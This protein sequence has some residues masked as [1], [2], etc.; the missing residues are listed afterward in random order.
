[1]RSSPEPPYSSG[2]PP[3][4]RPSS[5]AFFSSWAISPSLCCSSSGMSG[6]TSLVTNSS[7]AWPISRWS[8]VSSAGVKT[9]SA[10]GDSRRKP[11][12]GARIPGV[13]V[14]AISPPKY[15]RKALENAR[16]AH[17]A[18]DAHG[19]HAITRL[20]ALEFAQNCGGQLR[21]G[22]AER[23]AESNG[24][25][26]RIDAGWVETGE[27]NYGK[28]LRGEGLVQ[29]DDIDLLELQGGQAQRLGNREHRTDS[30]L[31]RRATSRGER[32]KSRERLHSQGAGAVSAHNNRD[33]GAIAP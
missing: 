23:M 18:A 3:P 6:A 31:F 28:R 5:P 8:S 16:G 2:T 21:A 10:R 24:A 17:A 19:N 11:P 14:V 27:A 7:A 32:H 29:L 25:A 4:K 12:P 13:A 33:H 30:H 9:S 15:L 26:I 1:M 20:A 22:A